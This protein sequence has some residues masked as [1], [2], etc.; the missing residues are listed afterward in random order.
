MTY[1][2]DTSAILAHYRQQTGADF[3]QAVF[4][5]EEIEIAI[6]SVS[7]AEFARRLFELGSTDIETAQTLVA[8]EA[9]FARIIP[10][11]QVVA[12]TAIHIS[13]QSPKRIPLID[14]LIAAVAKSCG[15]VLVHADAHMLAIPFDLVE[16]HYLIANQ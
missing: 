8:Y 1:V 6:A 4:D 10:I 5:N 11:D 12:Q 13:R 7:L 3:V 16:Q 9:L 14:A 2:F 15:A